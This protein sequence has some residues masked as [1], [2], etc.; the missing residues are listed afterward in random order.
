MNLDTATQIAQILGGITL[1]AAV[2]FGIVQVRQFRRQRQDM[3][4]VELMRS[5]QD[6]EF[7]RALRL[8]Y[9]LPTGIS[10][11]DLRARGIEYEDA[12]F[13]VSTK[14]ETIGLLVFRENIPFHIVE[15]LIGGTIVKL[16]RRLQPWA[17]QVRLEQE[18]KQFMEWFQWLGERLIERGRTEMPVAHEQYREW[19]PKS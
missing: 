17:E 10:A 13:T 3:A 8:L 18:Q 12:A 11:K 1:V 7:T 14:F 4:A 5:I 6:S 2:I 15:E 16:L 9:T 19:K